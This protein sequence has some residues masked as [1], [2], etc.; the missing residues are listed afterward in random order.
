MS[1]HRGYV[2]SFSDDSADFWEAEIGMEI[3]RYQGIADCADYLRWLDEHE[4]T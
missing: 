4:E 2:E 3:W 1:A